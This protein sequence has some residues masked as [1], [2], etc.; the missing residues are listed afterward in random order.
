M[1]PGPI[2]AYPRVL[3]AMSAQLL[4]QYDPEFTG[5]MNETMALYRHVFRTG[6]R[7]T[8][9]DRWQRPRA[10]IEA[11]LVSLIEPGDPVVVVNFGRFGLLLR[12][13]AERCGG[14]VTMVDAEWGTVV[15]ADAVRE[16]VRR[17]RPRLVA[18]VHGDTSTTMAQPIHE[19]RPHL[20]RAR[21]P[22]LCRCHRDAGRHGCPGG[23]LGC[24]HRDCR[25]AEMPR[26]PGRVGADHHLRACRDTDLFAQARRARHRPGWRPGCRHTPQQHLLSLRPDN[27]SPRTTSISPC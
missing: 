17:V 14:L 13:I 7:W 16:A 18:T 1:G 4:G 22:A 8:L 9:P 3:R 12:E 11:A 21:C 10:A 5:Y 15:E 20:R 2:N 25:A 19:L 6:N 26:R 27:G 24:R 23:R